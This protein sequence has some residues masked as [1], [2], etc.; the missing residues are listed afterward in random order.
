LRRD[1]TP[2]TAVIV[3][4]Y[5]REAGLLLRAVQSAL[6]Q[7]AVRTLV[8]VIDDESPT[9]ANEELRALSPDERKGIL[10]LTQRN[11]GPGA[12]RN[13][14]IDAV[15]DDIDYI[16][17]L[18]SDDTWAPDHL[19]R[20][21]QAMALGAD[22][23]FSKLPRDFAEVPAS[24]R[25]QIAKD[26]FE[27]DG[28]IFDALLR[29]SPVGT[30]SVV[31]RKAI[32]DGHR[33]PTD[34]SFAEDAFFWM[35]LLTGERRRVM[36]SARQTVVKGEGVNISAG[37]WG[38]PK[39]LSRT[40]WEYRFHWAVRRRFPLSQPQA[41][42]SVTYRRELVR[43]FLASFAHLAL[44]LRP[45][46]WRHVAGFVMTLAHDPDL[47]PFAKAASSVQAVAGRPDH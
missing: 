16:A 40:Y 22:L 11:G 8:I 13:T 19:E 28:D 42:W 6:A 14:G 30:P 41:Q 33:F 12:A 23:Y 36:F 35:L 37:A 45:I 15:P 31:Y 29:D 18:D 46:N 27:Y 17:F 39:H 43:G 1:D 7:T 47:A 2:S 34:F 38:T 25:I 5:Q 20:A 24:A 10:L 4:F 9:D 26:L 44:R 32:G 21:M 3:P